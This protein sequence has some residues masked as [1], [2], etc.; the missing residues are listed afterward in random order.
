MSCVIFPFV[1]KLF[2]MFVMFPL[3]VSLF[4]VQLNEHFSVVEFIFF[5]G[6]FIRR[7]FFGKG[8]KRSMLS[9]WFA[10]ALL[11]RIS[12]ICRR[13]MRE[14]RWNFRKQNITKLRSLTKEIVGK[15]ILCYYPQFCLHFGITPN[16]KKF[17][18]FQYMFWLYTVKVGGSSSSQIATCSWKSQ[19]HEIE[20]LMCPAQH[21]IL[22]FSSLNY[23]S[24]KENSPLPFSLSFSLISFC[25]SSFS[26]LPPVSFSFSST[27]P[28]SF[29]HL[30][31]ALPQK[32]EWPAQTS[33]GLSWEGD[34][35]NMARWEL[36]D[37]VKVRFYVRPTSRRPWRY[38]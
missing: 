17:R 1:V 30:H 9:V 4:T 36:Y 32:W 19:V 31:F 34:T 11:V 8:S 6:S 14:G 28:S 29:A 20:V 38:A 3:F 33:F 22:N 24:Q 21:T 16:F 10:N 5:C 2:P 26:P 27:L 12:R 15:L 35:R 18:A 23:T 25:S 7:A 13:S 37:A